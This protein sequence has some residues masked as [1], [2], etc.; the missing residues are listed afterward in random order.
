MR[1]MLIVRRAMLLVDTRR[2]FEAWS[3]PK[4]AFLYVSRAQYP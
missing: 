2:T 3:T 4:A 1:G